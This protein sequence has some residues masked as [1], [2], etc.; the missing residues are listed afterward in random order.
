M[1]GKEEMSWSQRENI[2]TLLFEMKKS[3]NRWKLYPDFPE[4]IRRGRWEQSK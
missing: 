2:K 1:N 3:T 4:I